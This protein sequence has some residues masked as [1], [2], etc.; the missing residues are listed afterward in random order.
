MLCLIA[1]GCSSSDNSTTT[2]PTDDDP[3]GGG[4]NGG[5]GNGGGGDIVGGVIEDKYNFEYMMVPFQTLIDPG[6]DPLISLE[7]DTENRVTRRDGGFRPIPPSLGFDFEYKTDLFDE[8]TYQAGSV[9]VERGTSGPYTLDDFRRT[10]TL[11][12]EGKVISKVIET[13]VPSETVMLTYEYDSNDMLVKT[14]VDPDDFETFYYFN[15]Q[16]NLDSVVTRTYNPD[17]SLNNRLVELFDD[18]DTH[19]N[20]TKDLFMFEEIFYRSLCENNFRWYSVTRYDGVTGAAQT[21]PRIV[22]WEFQFDS[23]GRIIWDAL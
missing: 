6:L 11:D 2:T 8:V 23:E 9:I 16:K 19:P 17:G 18:F 1:M 12:S 13:S 22:D 21:T 14:Y 10:H 20:P 5:N 15:A 3:I 7:R 4:G